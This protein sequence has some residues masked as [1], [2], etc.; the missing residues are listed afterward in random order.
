MV[1]DGYVAPAKT[2]IPVLGRDALGMIWAEMLNMSAGG[3]I[4]P[5][6][7]T[8]AKKAAYCM[9]GGDVKQGSLVS[10]E[11][12]MKLERE[13]FVD[14]WKTENTQKMAEHIVATGKP[15]MI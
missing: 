7:E 11:Y 5:H 13:A 4:T 8:I 2:K 15:L 10:E 1:A 6:M 12:L 3:Y 14:L 9:A